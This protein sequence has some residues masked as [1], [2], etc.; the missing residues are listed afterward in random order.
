[1][2]QVFDFL[3]F[4]S[5]DDKHSG[6]AV[7]EAWLQKVRAPISVYLGSYR[8]VGSVLP[9]HCDM[10]YD[11]RIRRRFPQAEITYLT[12]GHFDIL[13]DDVVIEGLQHGYLTRTR[14]RM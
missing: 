6:L 14:V 8:I 5:T 1:M 9:E 11:L 2:N 10:W 7:L 13:A 12:G 4:L 3:P